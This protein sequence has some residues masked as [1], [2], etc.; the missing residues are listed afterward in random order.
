MYKYKYFLFGIAGGQ[1]VDLTVMLQF[2][3]GVIFVDR[4]IN[5]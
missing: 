5:V 4:K 2:N 3:H 1:E